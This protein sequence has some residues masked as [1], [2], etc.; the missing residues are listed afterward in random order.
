MIK[1]CFDIELRLKI[2]EEERRRRRK[3]ADRHV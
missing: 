1:S 3:D 2:S